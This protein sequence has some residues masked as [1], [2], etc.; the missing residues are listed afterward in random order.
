MIAP[1]IKGHRPTTLLCIQIK[2]KEITK[3]LMMIAN[4]N[5]TFCPLWFIQPFH[6]DGN[7]AVMFTTND[8]VD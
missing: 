7:H 3:T 4:L 5:E 2:R 1:L 8:K 6:I